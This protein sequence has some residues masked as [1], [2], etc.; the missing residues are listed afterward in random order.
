LVLAAN[1]PTACKVIDFLTAIQVFNS[2][3][4]EETGPADIPVGVGHVLEA[5]HLERVHNTVVSVGR[6]RDFKAKRE[7]GFELLL[8][9]LYNPGVVFWELAL[10]FEERGIGEK[11]EWLS[12]RKRTF[13][14][15]DELVGFAAEVLVANGVFALLFGHVG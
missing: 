5:C 6:L 9:V 4:L 7:E 13:D 12:V 3:S 14:Q 2:S 11:Q 10:H 8:V 15:R 1:A